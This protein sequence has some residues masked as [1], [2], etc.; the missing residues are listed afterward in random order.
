MTLLADVGP[1]PGVALAMLG[2][3]VVAGVALSVGVVWA[4]IWLVRRE[5]KPP[6]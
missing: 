5:K 2:C 6:R 3:A 4:G 1:P